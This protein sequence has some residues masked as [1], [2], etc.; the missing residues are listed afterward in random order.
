[1]KSGYAIIISGS[2][3]LCLS[4]IGVKGQAFILNGSASSLGGDCYQLTPDVGGQAGSIFSQNTIDL[5]QAFNLDATLFFG[6]KDANGADGIVFI[7]TTSN[8]ALGNGGGGI[9]YEGITPSIAVEY[10]DYFNSGYNDPV[11]D[12]MA[13]TS[14]GV[15]NHSSS[16]NLSGPINLTNI[17]NCMEH[18]FAISWDPDSL[19]LTATLDGDTISYS[20]DI[21]ANIFSGNSQ[22]YYGFSAGTGSL[23]NIHRVCFGPPPLDAMHDVNICEGESIELQADPDGIAWTWAPDPSLTPLNVSNPTATPD[24]STTYTVII[25]YACGYFGYD[26]VMVTIMPAPF[27]SASNNGPVCEGE[28]LSLMS[29]GGISYHWS[30]PSGYSSFSQNPVINNTNAGMAGIYFVTVTDGAGCSAIASTLVEIDTGPL[31][32]ITPPP[33]LLCANDDPIQ[34]TASPSGG[35]WSG[36]ISVNGLFDPGYA[37]EGVHLVTYTATNSNGCTNTA[38]V[39]LEVAMIPEVLIDPPG[40]LCEE[41]NPIQMTGSPSGGVWSG[42]I[43]ING[44]FD[45]E[46]AGDG[47]HLITYTAND[48]NGCT[49]SAEIVVEVVADLPADIAPTGPFCINDS[50]IM[51]IATPTGGEWGGIANNAGIIF[52]GNLG[53][54]FHLVTYSLIDQNGCYFGQ[55]DIEILALPV[56]SIDTISPLCLDLPLQMLTATPPGGTWTGAANSSGQVDPDSLGSGSHQVIY[57]YTLP[58]GCS[59]ADTISIIVLPDPPRINNLNVTC[60]SL[61]TSYVVT[62]TISG[63]D[64]LSYTVTGSVTGTL[65]PGNPFIFTSQPIASGNP[66]SFVVDDIHHC[67]SVTTSGSSLCNCATNAGMMD[68]NQVAICED[69]TISV[70][71]PTGVVLDPDD[72]LVYV[73]HLGFPD[74]ILMI[75]N[76]NEFIFGPPLQ[77]GVNYFISTI[78]GNALQGNGVDLSDPCLSVSFGTPVIWINNPSGYLDGLSPICEG[79]SSSLSFILTGIGPYNVVF[80]DGS[81]FFTVDSILSGHSVSVS[82]AN[83]T[84]YTLLEV[85]DLSFPGCT[86]APDTDALIEVNNNFLMQQPAR[87]CAGDSIFLGGAFQTNEGVYFDNLTSINGCDSII[88]TSLIVNE[89]DTTFLNATSCDT[90]Q[91]G[92]FVEINV[93]QFG[94]D[95]TTIRTVAYVESYTTMIQSHTC[96]L[97]DAGIFTETFT[98]QSGCDSIVIETILFI[99]PDTTLLSSETCDTATA[100]TFIQTFFNAL[101]CDSLV[102]ETVEFIPADTT[103]ISGET[104]DASSAGI[105]MQ[106]LSNVEG[107]DSFIIGTISLL[108]SDTLINYTMTC[109]PQDTGTL[110]QVLTNVDG[111]DSMLLT[112]TLLAPEDTCN[113]P[114]IIKNVFIPDVFSPNDDDFNDVF[115]V[116][117]RQGS[118]SKISFLRI[119]DRWGG[120]VL[121]RHDF[122]PNDPDYGWDGTEMG[123][124]VGP[125]VFVWMVGIEYTDGSREA[126]TGNVTLIR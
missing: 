107:C 28:S 58:G 105:F 95:S 42:D 88:E 9:G 3:L 5:T 64:P 25:E 125:G 48:G 12:H 40:I 23:S 32:N 52:P 104:C 2:F 77:T 45:P 121:E 13:V 96:E 116:F 68:L 24:I 118:V 93:N 67:D 20:G 110:V 39:A 27:A 76:S 6:C 113:V 89:P 10:D 99:P 43:S 57:E 102:I 4:S 55:E 115:L 36:D 100:G 114:V 34:L 91:T 92:V 8:T 123:K 22:V 15:M 122:Q 81:G 86:S 46:D 119:F 74:S 14:N 98:S 21:V 101:G 65:I 54:G 97:Q 37:G 50:V 51:L 63:G 56:V 62:F 90:A 109:S 117:A 94:C 7:L 18:C 44:V 19:I 79:D 53:A 111:C 80:T 41:G 29:S 60:D 16:T 61:A 83:T 17:E 11:P 1:M 126:R 71:P 31:I 75:S 35:I 106:T 70:L 124:P 84:L 69:D 78:A 47:P 30:G 85:C 103:R 73:L 49:N 66:Y 33:L 108:P 38:Q 72:S 26:T 59:D 112:I 82:P 87:I 120:L